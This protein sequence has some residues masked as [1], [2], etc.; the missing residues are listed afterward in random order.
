MW[1]VRAAAFSDA[2]PHHA[3]TMLASRLSV[4]RDR[5]RSLQPLARL[6][7]PM[8]AEVVSLEHYRRASA[9]RS[10]SPSLLLQK[11]P[12]E[13]D[14]GMA[15][16]LRRDEQRW[17]DHRDE[18]RHSVQGKCMPLVT[19]NGSA[20]R[21]ENVSRTGLKI[22]CDVDAHLGSRLLLTIA[23]CPSLSARLIWRRG[24]MLGLEAPMA[25]MS[26]GSV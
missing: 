20:A 22:R 26:L 15:A 4:P 16:M 23:G 12:L 14:Q 5:L 2:L 1:P 3:E 9:A 25:S 19:V 6:A 7:A 10:A 24:G 13:R 11:Q 18:P 21:L 8:T 17:A